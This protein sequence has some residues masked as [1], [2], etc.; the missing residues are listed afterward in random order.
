M[1][2]SRRRLPEDGEGRSLRTV[3]GGMSIVGQD[4]GITRE[5]SNMI[6]GISD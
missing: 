4:R 6:D 2:D 5:A 3:E 1:E